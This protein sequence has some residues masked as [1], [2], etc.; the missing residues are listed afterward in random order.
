M[1]RLIDP[2][3]QRIG[4]NAHGYAAKALHAGGIYREK[5]ANSPQAALPCE[6]G[7]GKCP[8]CK[9]RRQVLFNGRCFYCRMYGFG[10]MGDE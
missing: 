2:S 4:R 3:R 7:F 8:A 5:S 1:A 10:G 9:R 6:H